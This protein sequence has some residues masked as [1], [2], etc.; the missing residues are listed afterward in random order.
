MKGVGNVRTPYRFLSVSVFGV[1]AAVAVSIWHECDELSLSTAFNWAT[2]FSEAT[3]SE[4]NAADASG[5]LVQE[6][7]RR[8]AQRPQIGSSLPVSNQRNSLQM[9]RTFRDA[10]GTSWKST[11][12]LRREDETVALGAVIDKDGWIISKDSQLPRSAT[13][14]CRFFD[15][16]ESIAERVASDSSLDLVLMKVPDRNLRVIE[17]ASD[18]LPARGNWVATT[19][20]H[21]TPVAVG[22]VSAG[23]LSVAPK[24][25]VLGVVLEDA[26]EG[27][28]VRD[29][30]RGTGADM[31][32]IRKGDVIRS[33][34]GQKLTG[35][36]A[37]F[38]LLESCNPGQSIQLE[39]VRGQSEVEAY[40]QMM[41]L[42]HELHDSTEMEVNGLI[43]AR[44]SG[45]RS[46]F[47]HD[48]VLL[49]TQCGGPLVDLNGQ[50]VGINIARA[51][52]VT[53]Y[54]LPTSTV[55]P[56]I[57]NMLASAKND[58]VVPANAN[59]SV[60][61]AEVR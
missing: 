46:V 16:N 5:I 36:T 8:R 48:T 15:G 1:A 25:A 43:S 57:E 26:K 4:V 58:Q 61:A 42:S 23:V 41:D 56:V 29:V 49:P 14:V 7:S 35:R 2:A 45:F 24:K 18:A 31:A 3:S 12:E 34:N 6:P 17:W 51:G 47:L 55:R 52:R 9:L 32:G 39:L 11:V 30:L 33:I 44:S 53:S 54:A 13:I 59:V 60:R 37:A 19:D 10:I 21:S 22:V 40:A 28:L 38:S 20:T 27:A 50:V